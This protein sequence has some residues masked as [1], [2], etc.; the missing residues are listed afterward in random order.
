MTMHT[1]DTTAVIDPLA[2]A[3]YP[4]PGRCTDRAGERAKHATHPSTHVHRPMGGA[5]RRRPVRL[6]V[7]GAARA[8]LAPGRTENVLS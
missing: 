2:S 7:L 8:T 6:A 3:H 1:T 4:A 5:P